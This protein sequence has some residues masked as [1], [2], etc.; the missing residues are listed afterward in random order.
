M[1]LSVPDRSTF[2]G[3]DYRDKL[4]LLSEGSVNRKF[5]PYLD[6]D[7]DSEA[8]RIDRDDPRWVLDPELD[9]LGA[10]QWYRSL[11][12]SRQIE[13]GRYR[14]ANAVRV[15]A[16]FESIL[17]RGMMQYIFK[18][19][20]NTPEFRYCL[21]EMTEECNHIQMFQELVNRIGDDVE[22]MRPMFRRLSP[23]IGVA[24]GYAHTILFIGI[25]G[26]EEPIDHYQKALI[27]QGVDLPPAVLRTMQIHIAEE[28]RHISFAHEFL[29]VHIERMSPA[30]RAVC[31]VAFPIAMAWLVNEIM[32]PSKSF[33]EKFGIPR[34]VM[35]E[36]FWK[37][38]QARKIRA[39][40]FDDVRTLVDDLG[41]L[42]RP[43]KL[44]WKAFG[45]SGDTSRYRSE[46]ARRAA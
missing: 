17:I 15:G 8:F 39:S 46:P 12:Q 3:A 1:T 14:L 18:L 19:P 44:L 32:A 38:P 35:R 4:E 34:E 13:I 11:P 27:R 25:L 42:N 31:S 22:G 24:G 23:W 26:G 10:T 28:A 40:Y 20:H 9:P 41:L 16:A 6:I 37:S 30:G 5:D 36:A 43:A 21:H 29:K 2:F 45:L 7:W 33:G